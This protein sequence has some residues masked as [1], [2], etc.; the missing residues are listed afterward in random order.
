[1]VGAVAKRLVR[2]NPDRS[3][4]EQWPEHLLC[5]WLRNFIE[6]LLSRCSSL[7]RGINGYF[8]FFLPR[9]CHCWSSH[10]SHLVYRAKNSPSLSFVTIH[11]DIDIAD[12]SSMQ[13]VCHSKNSV[14]K[15]ASLPM[16]SRSSAVDRAPAWCSGGHG[17]NSWR[18]LRFFSLSHARVIVDHF[19]F[20]HI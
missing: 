5:F 13:D 6:S 15:M 11:D 8:C 9:S 10:L 16:I 1:M 2:R 20:S 19:I 18:G 4:F 3:G 7:P 12:P 14:L 17:F